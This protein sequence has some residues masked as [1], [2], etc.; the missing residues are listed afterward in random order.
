M[1]IKAAWF[2]VAICILVPIHELG[3]FY[4]MRRFGV[5]VLRFSVGFGNR[6]VT[7][8]DSKGTEF[9]ISSI[10]LGGYVKP[11]DERSED[12]T[13][14]QMHLTLNAQPIWQRIIIFA[15]GPLANLVLAVVFYWALLL[16][17]GTVSYSPVIGEVEPGSIGEQAGL[18]AN[19]E[20]VEIDGKATPTRRDVRLQLLSRLGETGAIRF[21]IRYPDSTLTYEKDVLIENWLDDV[22]APD[23]TEGLGFEFYYPR[24]GREL[25]LVVEGSAAEAAGMK[26]GDV[27][28]AM[29]GRKIEEWEDWVYYVRARPEQILE[30]IVDRAG[31]E[32]ALTL[33]PERLK[34]DGGDVIG[35]AGVRVVLPKM[36][37][38]MVRIHRYNLLDAMTS[39][40]NETWET[41]K[42]I[43]ISMKKLILGEISTKNLSGPIGIA[44]VAA[45]HAELG[46]WAFL[47]FLAHLSIVLGIMNLLPV[48]MLDGGHIVFAVVEWI[49]GS[50]VSQEVQ[51]WSLNVG[52]MLLVSVMMVAFYNDLLGP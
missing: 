26:S 47:S 46:F 11:L 52:V 39:A 4:A 41:S 23:P 16:I 9:A 40:M 22:K 43:L 6:L 45:S 27:L 13:E 49:K 48:P 38:E 24:I 17:K 1:L 8:T 36:P 28:V 29:D 21:V 37:E 14:D 5:K 33:T 18:E 31:E 51:A 35:R 34:I 2:L 7:W 44:K 25:D 19:T 10:P 32:L 50:P 20:I 15:A 3:H 30:V 42:F 12:V